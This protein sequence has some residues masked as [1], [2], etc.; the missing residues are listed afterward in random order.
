MRHTDWL[1]LKTQGENIC[2]VLRQQ[3]YQCRKQTRRLSWKVRKDSDAYVLKW[4]P[5]PVGNWSLIPNDT[6]PAREQLMA[7]VQSALK[8]R[9][10]GR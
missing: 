7:I 3:G 1:R 6:N 8:G 2:A 4:L 10:T 9:G 5:A